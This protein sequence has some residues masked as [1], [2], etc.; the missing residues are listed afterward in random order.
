MDG[1]KTAE[2]AEDAECSKVKNLEPQGTQS[3]SSE[4]MSGLWIGIAHSTLR[5]SRRVGQPRCPRISTLQ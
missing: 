3:G 4:S 5:K 1:M 2:D